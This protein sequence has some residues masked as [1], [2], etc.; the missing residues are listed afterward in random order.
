MKKR[1]R[2]NA[3]PVVEDKES[4]HDYSVDARR[5]VASVARTYKDEGKTWADVDAFLSKATPG[6]P[7]RT[8]RAWVSALRRGEDPFK[9]EKDGGRPQVLT[10]E[11]LRILV[12]WILFETDREEI[13]KLRDATA[14]LNDKLGLEVVEETVRL[15]LGPMG[16][17]VKPARLKAVKKKLPK[18]LLPI[19]K[20][21]I[22]EM[23]RKYGNKT[24]FISL[25]FTY[26]SHRTARPSTL[27][28]AGKPVKSVSR[29][30]RFTN[31]IITALCSDGTQFPSSC[32]TL[33][34]AFRTDRQ[35]TKRRAGL[36]NH[37]EQVLAEHQM[38]DDRF[39][40]EGKLRGEKGTFAGESSEMVLDYLEQVKHLFEGREVVFLTD[41]GGAFKDGDKKIIEEAGYGKQ[42]FYPAAVHQ[43]ASP[44]DNNLHGVGKAKW[45]SIFKDFEDDVAATVF[46]MAQFDAVSGD[47]IRHWFQRNL[48]L[49]AG[50]VRDEDILQLIDE[51]ISKWSRL[52]EE[53]LIC[54]EEFAGIAPAPTI[55]DRRLSCE[56]DGLKWK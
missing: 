38:E 30:S 9:D 50:K 13:V 5:V 47:T 34:S 16:I 31:T 21:W 23:R 17:K 12:G 7:V 44:N 18:K 25:D 20:E 37:F 54:Y 41:N 3:L 49:G 26:T 11:Q 14:F 8:A 51:K 43:Y 42:E 15:R 33:N 46:L 2:S 24:V 19:Y 56:L 32:Y 39:C 22:L 52:H 4:T 53:C 29:I 45:R 27:A 28:P 10:D 6:I 55:E 40:Y 48:F 36:V 35:S 1:A